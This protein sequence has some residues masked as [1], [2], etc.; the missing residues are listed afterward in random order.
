M[1]GLLSILANHEYSYL[2]FMRFVNFLDLRKKITAPGSRLEREPVSRSKFISKTQNY[3]S[4]TTSRANIHTNVK[5]R[6][7]GAWE[8]SSSHVKPKVSR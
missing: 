2:G 1:R 8:S 5:S 3:P 7:T 4:T 6:L